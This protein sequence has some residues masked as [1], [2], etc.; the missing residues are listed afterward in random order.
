MGILN[1]LSYD[2]VKD[3]LSKTEK[4]EEFFYI[5]KNDYSTILI[6][7]NGTADK[8]QGIILIRIK[9]KRKIGKIFSIE[10]FKNGEK[11]TKGS[12]VDRPTLI[13]F[14]LQVVFLVL[15]KCQF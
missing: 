8:R 14:G 1:Q 15:K 5:L 3:N 13:N 2:N 7:I 4:I 12:F 10:K 11:Y 9:A 6:K